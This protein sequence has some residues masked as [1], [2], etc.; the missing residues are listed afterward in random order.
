M[1]WRGRQTARGF[2][3]Y[4]TVVFGAAMVLIGATLFRI[5]I[6]EFTLSAALRESEY[7]FNAADA[8][9]ECALYWD[10]QGTN[11]FPTYGISGNFYVALFGVAD[12]ANDPPANLAQIRCNGGVPVISS[13]FGYSTLAFNQYAYSQFYFD[14]DGKYCSTVY[15]YKNTDLLTGIVQ[16]AII[17]L[18]YN[19]L[20]TQLNSV[21]A[22]QR[23]IITEYP[24]S[25]YLELF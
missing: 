18:G 16:T 19:K 5:S 10:L 22:V 6:K 11:T 15:V 25:L 20:C 13:V 17:S 9:T 2:T 21:D 24:D 1:V 4:Y 12:P 7:A 14:L 23:A 3:I 8:G